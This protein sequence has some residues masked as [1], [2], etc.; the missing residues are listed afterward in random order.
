MTHSKSKTLSL[1]PNVQ[2]PGNLKPCYKF[3]FLCC[4][5]VY[6]SKLSNSDHEVHFFYQGSPKIC[7]EGSIWGS[8][9][10][11]EGPLGSEFHN[12]QKCVPK[13]L[14]GLKSI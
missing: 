11:Q 7:L 4:L 1:E 5:E 8:M 6:V 13:C 3:M 14:K 9:K 10:V 12:E 2:C